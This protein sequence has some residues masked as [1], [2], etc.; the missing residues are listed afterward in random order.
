MWQSMLQ[1]DYHMYN[2]FLGKIAACFEQEFKA[3]L[4]LW[5]VHLGTMHGV[6]IL[7]ELVSCD[8]HC[9]S[10]ILFK[11][12]HDATKSKTANMC[13]V[14]IAQIRKS[15]QRD[16]SQNKTHSLRHVL[17][18]AHMIYLTFNMLAPM[19]CQHWRCVCFKYSSN[20]N[21]I[22]AGCCR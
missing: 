16:S 10:Y 2:M 15:R 19:Y 6:S 18:N 21:G 22:S 14:A 5:L 7:N 8:M 4:R 11:V 9:T 20:C 1:S 13:I 12:D 3:E 17:S